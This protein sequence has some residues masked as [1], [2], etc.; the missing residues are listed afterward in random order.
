MTPLFSAACVAAIPGDPN[1]APRS[2]FGDSDKTFCGSSRTPFEILTICALLKGTVT[3]TVRTRMESVTRID[4]ARLPISNLQKYAGKTI[5]PPEAGQGD[6]SLDF[7]HTAARCSVRFDAAATPPARARP[8]KRK[9]LRKS[10]FDLPESA[11]G[12]GTKK[13]GRPR[14]PQSD[15][16]DRKTSAYRTR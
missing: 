1:R 7:C 16:P 8:A 3:A 6:S 2:T 10:N 4:V 14:G 9:L 11:L 12:I 15:W 13:C 5:L